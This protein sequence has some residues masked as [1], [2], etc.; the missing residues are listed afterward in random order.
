M[1]NF[2]A[3]FHVKTGSSGESTVA[4]SPS[5]VPVQLTAKHPVRLLRAS[6]GDEAGR[7]KR[8][9]RTQRAWPTCLIGEP[10]ASESA[11]EPAPEFT[12]PRITRLGR[13]RTMF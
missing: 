12:F 11:I 9:N 7:E 1:E 8:A 2:L 13:L 6:T 4:V 10:S 5:T 3:K